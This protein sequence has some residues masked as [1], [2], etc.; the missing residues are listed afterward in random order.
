M[1]WVHVLW[2][3]WIRLY[4][5]IGYKDFL[6]ILLCIWFQYIY[7][8]GYSV[9]DW[10]ILDSGYWNLIVFRLQMF[11]CNSSNDT[12]NIVFSTTSAILEKGNTNASTTIHSFFLLTIPSHTS[13]F[14][15]SSFIWHASADITYIYCTVLCRGATVKSQTPNLKRKVGRPTWSLI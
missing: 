6:S 9:I 7:V 8:S 15:L 11:G 2:E 10:E 13:F 14:H 4:M 1:K 3:P 5:I 12:L